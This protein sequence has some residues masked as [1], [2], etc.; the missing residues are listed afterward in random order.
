MLCAVAGTLGALNCVTHA[1]K[2]TAALTHTK[3]PGWSGQKSGTKTTS[4]NKKKEEVA[5]Y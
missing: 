2:P 1:Q 3:E 5:L 4:S